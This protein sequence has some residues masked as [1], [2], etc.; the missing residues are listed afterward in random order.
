MTSTNGHDPDEDRKD[1]IV[2]LPSLA[3]RDRLRKQ[4]EQEVRKRMAK[5]EPQKEPMFNMPP[6]TKYMLGLFIGLHVIL[7]FLP[8][9][10]NWMILNFGFIPGR[11]TGQAPFTI[12]TLFTPITYMLLHGSWVH[13]GMNVLMLAAFGSG[14]ER[15]LGAK[16]MIIFFILCGLCGIAVHFIIYMNELSPVVGASGGLSGMFAA[17]LVMLNRERAGH[18]FKSNILPIALLWVGISVI[19]GVLGSPDGSS[20]AWLAHIGGFL[21]GFLILKL[22]KI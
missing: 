22:M 5:A 6:A 18:G 10:Q 20:I 9:L 13:L 3:E 12:Y 19:F 8:D 4:A 15:W 16:R 17:A 2:Q 14:V 7:T 11:F 1:N 21:G